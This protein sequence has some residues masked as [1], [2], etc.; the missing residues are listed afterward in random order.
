MALTD[1]RPTTADRDAV[2]AQLGTLLSTIA[3][4]PD[5]LHRLDLL[6]SCVDGVDRGT[7]IAVAACRD[8]AVT[9][10][11]IADGLG[12]ASRQTAQQ[13]YGR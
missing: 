13:R 2:Y 4:V 7:E 10:D 3:A 11:L 8:L 12:L 9:W 6:R 5:P 1:T